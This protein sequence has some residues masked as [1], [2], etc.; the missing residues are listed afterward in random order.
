[1]TIEQAIEELGNLVSENGG[2]GDEALDVVKDTISHLRH[3]IRYLT[4]RRSN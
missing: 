2:K 1:M 4:G 3:E